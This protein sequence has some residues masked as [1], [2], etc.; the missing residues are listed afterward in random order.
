MWLRNLL[1]L[2]LI[3]GGARALGANL[4]PPRDP[5]A[6]AKHDAGLNETPDFRAAVERVDASFHQQWAEQKRKEA[7]A[8]KRLV[9]K[10][11]DLRRREAALKTANVRQHEEARRP[12][13]FGR[14]GLFGGPRPGMFGGGMFR[15]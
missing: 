4:V 6:V 5:K 3:G 8:H 10:E 7:A 11:A 12:M 9:A 13:H 15:R 2:G 14:A 1:F